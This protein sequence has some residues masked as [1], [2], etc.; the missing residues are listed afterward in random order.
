M[1]LKLV[2]VFVEDPITAFKYYTETLGFVE[3]IYIPDALLAIVAS[4]EDRDGTQLLL[5]PTGNLGAREFQQG[6]YQAKLP[7]IVFGTDDIQKDYERLKKLGVVFSKE[8]TKT[9]YGTETVFEDTC[10][11]LIQLVQA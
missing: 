6:I 4:P 11:N 7:A 3:K 10:G 5:E 9:D 1:K 8:P 2:S